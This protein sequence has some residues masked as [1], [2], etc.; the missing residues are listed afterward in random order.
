MSGEDFKLCND[1]YLRLEQVGEEPSDELYQTIVLAWSASGA[2]GN[3]GFEYLFEGA[4][5]DR[6]PGYARTL[7][8]YERLGAIASAAALREALGWLGVPPPSDSARRIERFKTV[9]KEERERVAKQ[10]WSGKA[11]L[12]RQLANYIR[13]HEAELA[14]RDAT[15]VG[16]LEDL[17]IM[18]P[19]RLEQLVDREVVQS[20]D[21]GE[22]EAD[23]R[24]ERSFVPVLPLV[25]VALAFAASAVLLSPVWSAPAVVAAILAL[26]EL[27]PRAWLVLSRGS[28]RVKLGGWSSMDGT[29]FSFVTEVVKRSRNFLTRFGVE[30]MDH[31]D[32][33]DDDRHVAR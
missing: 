30:D 10:F 22:W 8:A 5:Y 19:N 12:E 18:E 32:D 28:E 20:Y 2:I 17:R 6:D 7:A 29:T 24:V 1:T 26:H 16:A 9:P 13:A 31:V 15:S 3:G 21:L 23:L 25:T 11:E 14:A 33:D 27:R 4:F